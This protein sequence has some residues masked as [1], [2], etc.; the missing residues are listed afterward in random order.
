[1]ASAGQLAV[2]ARVVAAGIVAPVAACFEVLAFGG[3]VVEAEGFGDD[4]GGG[5][6]DELAERGDPCGPQGEAEVA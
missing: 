1:M 2:S 3:G 5:L 6:E 4:G